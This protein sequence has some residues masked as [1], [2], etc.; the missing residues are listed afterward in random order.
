MASQVCAGFLEFLED[1]EPVQETDFLNPLPFISYYERMRG[2]SLTVH[3]SLS[4][5]II[6]EESCILGDYQYIPA[7]SVI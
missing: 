2:S 7:R 5:L 6:I 4:F 1:N 3:L